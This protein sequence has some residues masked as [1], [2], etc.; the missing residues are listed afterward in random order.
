MHKDRKDVKAGDKRTRD[1]V[2]SVSDNS[3]CEQVSVKQ[4]KKKQKDVKTNQSINDKLKNFITKDSKELK[5]LVKELVIQLKEELLSTFIKRLY[6]KEGEPFDKEIENTKRTKQLDDILEDLK[7]QK[8]ENERL[9][10]AMKNNEYAN[11]LYKNEIEQYSRR[12]NM[13]IEGG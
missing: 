11:Q 3:M 9:K 2:S 13:R 1:N 4:K 10:K 12:N 5:D 8:E 6:K 7:K